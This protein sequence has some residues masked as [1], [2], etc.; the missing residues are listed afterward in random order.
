LGYCLMLEQIMERF[1]RFTKLIVGTRIHA[2]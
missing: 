2:G 1:F